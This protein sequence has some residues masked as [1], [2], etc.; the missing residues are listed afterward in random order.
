[1]AAVPRDVVEAARIDGAGHLAILVRIVIPLCSPAIAAFAV[2]QFI[3]VWNDLLV[4]LA[5]AGTSPDVVPITPYLAST[6]AAHADQPA[7][8]A[9]LA[10]VAIVVPS[11]VLATA[12]RQFVRGVRA[13][14]LGA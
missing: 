4:A 12:Q 3:W 2:L 13:S 5:F 8:V 14:T 7:R 11:L 6:K 1:M 10:C 9:A